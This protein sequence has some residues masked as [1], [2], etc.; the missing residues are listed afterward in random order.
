M[1]QSSQQARTPVV[2]IGPALDEA[3]FLHPV[4]HAAE[5]DRLDLEPLGVERLIAA[6]MPLEIEQQAGLRR[7]HP[8]FPHPLVESAAQQAGVVRK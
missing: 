4:D 7:R 3:G 8:C 5:R 2:R 1:G 6:W